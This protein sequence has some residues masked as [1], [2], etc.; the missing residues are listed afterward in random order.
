MRAVVS[1]AEM[2][3]AEEEASTRGLTSAALMQLA[4]LGAADFLLGHPRGKESRYLVLAGPGNNGGDALVVAGLLAANGAP[5]QIVTYR[6]PQPSP[7]DPPGLP[8]FDCGDDPDLERL[9]SAILACQ[10]IVDGILGTGRAR[11]IEPDL[12][13]ILAEVRAASDRRHIVA[14]DLPTGVDATSGAADPNALFAHQTITFGYEK[15][16]LRLS[17]ARELAGKVRLV[18]IGLPAPPVI[19]VATHM[20]EAADVAGWLPT[21]SPTTHKY[22]AGA[23]L[24]LAGSPVYTG[25]PVLCS[26]AAL[27][28]GAGYVTLAVREA[29][30]AT[31]A[32]MVVSPTMLV[33]PDAWEV[34]MACL[35]E[36]AGR[37]HALLIGPGLGR[38]PDTISLVRA[39]LSTPPPGPRA[40]VVDAD[41]LFALSET[42]NWWERAPLPLVL[43]PH[44]GEM[45]R[46]TGLSGEEIEGNRLEV[47]TTW[48]RR[49]GQILVLK[50]APTIV[51]SPEGEL[52]LN[53]TGN[54]LLATAGTGDVLSGIIAAFLAGG[55]AP[56]SAA[57]A[58]VYIHGLA[59]DLGIETYGDR[60][61]LAGDLLPLIPQAIKVVLA[62]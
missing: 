51:A 43:T 20:P 5:V 27:R 36:N 9:R 28:S 58:A 21:R 10:V 30:R 4:A 53:P 55:A 8:R 25:A 17:P 13:A 6:R 32:S 39:L 47:A 40:A 60:G 49:W 16:G 54:P 31:L 37:Y 18:E 29:T 7:V 52:S 12:A 11:P 34:A 62:S 19:P 33:V 1:A 2:R 24:A 42:P 41:A 23:V 14:L 46:L 56:F 48:A 61:L 59:A 45:A 3:A 35:R 38:E 22:T 15:R 50:G 44:T 26:T 57:R